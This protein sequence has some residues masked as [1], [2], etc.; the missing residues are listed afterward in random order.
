MRAGTAPPPEVVDT[1]R[2]ST[3]TTGC[4]CTTSFTTIA[5][6]PSFARNTTRTKP[7]TSFIDYFWTL[8]TMH[9]PL[10][11]LASIARS[12][13]RFRALHAVSTGY[14]GALG[15]HVYRRTQAPF[16]LTEHGIYTKE[17]KIDPAQA[18]W[19]KDEP[20]VAVPAAR[21]AT[22]GSS[23]SVLRGAG[24]DDLRRRGPDRRALRR[25]PPPT[26]QGRRVT[27]RTSV[28]PNGID[29]HGSRRCGADD[30]AT[31]RRPRPASGASFRSR[32]S[33]PSSARCAIVAAR[34]TRRA[35]SSA[36]RT[37]TTATPRNARRWWPAWACRRREF[38]GFLRRRR[39]CPE[40]GVAVLDLDQRGAAALRARGFRGRRA[41]RRHRRRLLSRAHRGAGEATAI[42]PARRHSSP[43]SPRHKRPRARSSN[44]AGPAAWTARARVTRPVSRALW[45][46]PDAGGLPRHPRSALRGN[47]RHW[48][49]FVGC[50]IG[51]ASGGSSGRM[52]TP[53]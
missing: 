31:R 50:S 7:E 11:K 45:P 14:A 35:G 23:G 32:T 41:G 24:P 34:P 6:S 30:L 33:R 10:F 18:A 53:A 17:R 15:A 2:R 21:S 9:V 36:P 47:G 44:A 38:L 4:R 1:R 12:L 37:R 42:R 5:S 19:I 3:A 49:R 22:C 28:I 29:L 39:S 20:G 27:E 13:P 51:T 16:I 46:R 40:L 26:G 52:P 43:R 8:R 25:E 48:L